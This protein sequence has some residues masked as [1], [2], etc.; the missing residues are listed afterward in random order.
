MLVARA[1]LPRAPDAPPP[2]HDPRGAGRRRHRPAEG[3]LVQ[4]GL[5]RGPAQGGHAAAAAGRLE[6]GRGGPT[7]RVAEHEIARRGRRALGRHT[8]GLV[9][10]YPATEGLSARRIRELRL[11]PARPGARTRSSRCRR[12]SA[13]ASALPA[14]ADALRARALARRASEVRRGAPPPRVRGAVAVPAGARRRAAARAQEARAGGALAAPGELVARWLESLPFELTGGQREALEE[15]DAD[16]ASGQPMQRL[17][18]GEVG[19][20]KTVVALYAML[21]V[22]EAGHAGGA[23]GADRDARR[24]ALRDA[25]AADPATCSPA[26]RRPG[27]GRRSAC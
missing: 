16:L 10:V 7:F 24:A 11:E 27:S 9:P 4:P 14:R 2:A 26:R 22:A 18:M 23:D 15:I 17:L 21:R 25:R 12:G 20:G 6:G 3:G 8:T 13:R 1:R 19:S 5:P